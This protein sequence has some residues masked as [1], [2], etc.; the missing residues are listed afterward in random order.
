MR[1]MWV[2]VAGAAG[3]L[4]RYGIGLAAGPQF[5]PWPTLGINLAG[6]FVLA[7]LLQH[8]TGRWP[9]D[10]QIAVA[11]GFLGAFT[12]FSTFGYETLVLLREGRGGRAALY[13][14]ASVVGG[15]GAGALGWA[16]ARP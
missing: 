9:V 5:F 12:T 14:V 2:G 10:F 16:L 3:A 8:G 13:V 15:L 6:C 4:C 7:F 11:V 1:A